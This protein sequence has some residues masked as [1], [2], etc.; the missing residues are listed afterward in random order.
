MTVYGDKLKLARDRATIHKNVETVRGLYRETKERG[1]GNMIPTML[2]WER[3]YDAIAFGCLSRFRLRNPKNQHELEK[4]LEHSIEMVR[5]ARER[6]A[7]I[8]YVE[9]GRVVLSPIEC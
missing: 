9:K 7:M 2:V 4:I 1:I 3:K 8:V 5:K 6:F